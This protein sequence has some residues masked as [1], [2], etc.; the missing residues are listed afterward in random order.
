MPMD[1]TS[2]P[3]QRDTLYRE[4]ETGGGSLEGGL[5]IENMLLEEY[6]YAATTAYQAM[7]DRARMFNMYL[8]VVGILGSAFGAIYPLGGSSARTF[9]Q[10]IA[11]VVLF[12]A[13]IAGIAFFALLIRL[14]QAFRQSLI[15]MAVIKEFYIREFQPQM[16]N[17]QHVFRWRLGTI[18][19]GERAGSATFI[20]CHMVG[21]IAALCFAGCI[22]MTNE[23]LTSAVPATQFAALNG[24]Q[25]LLLGLLAFVITMVWMVGAYRRALSVKDELKNL[26]DAKQE[27][28]MI[29]Q[30]DGK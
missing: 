6:N 28:A 27:V 4:R 9:I 19:S 15:T 30:P 18:P 11:A 7:E 23:L 10:P 14:R 12:A 20:V 21:F 5:K 2:P 29:G 16:P 13:G 24:W 25:S 22:F 3:E 8:L 17:I 26:A 1:R